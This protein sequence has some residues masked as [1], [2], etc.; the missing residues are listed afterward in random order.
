MTGPWW[1]PEEVEQLKGLLFCTWIGLLYGVCASAVAD[2]SWSI[3]F[4]VVALVTGS[5][6]LGVGRR[7]LRLGAP[8]VLFI[9][10]LAIFRLIPA[11]DD[12]RNFA[13]EP[14]AWIR[15]LVG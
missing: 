12:L 15:A 9:T 7:L 14:M 3:F 6:Y 11:A 5:H 10:L 1:D 4:L 2:V 8:L 13:H